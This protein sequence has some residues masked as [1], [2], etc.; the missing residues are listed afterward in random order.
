MATRK[1]KTQK[2]NAIPQEIKNEADRMVSNGL[3]EAFLGYNPQTSVQLSQVDTLFKN[4]RWY[5]ISNM[6]QVLSEIYVEHGLIQTIVDVPVDDGLRGG[7]K[8]KSDQLSE[9]QIQD[10]ETAI[11]RDDDLNTIGQAVKWTRLFGGGAILVITGQDPTL[12]LDVNSIAVGSP[13]EFRAVDMWELYW[14]KQ[15][16]EGFSAELQD[17]VFEYY[18]YYGKKVHKSRVMKMKGLTAPS[19]IRPRLRGWGF[20]IVEAIVRSINQYLKSNDLSFEVLDEFK[21]DVFKLK[22]LT[23][24]LLAPQ[25]E[26]KVRARVQLANRQKNYQNAIVLDGEDDYDHK[27]LSFAGLAEAMEGIRMQIASDLRMPL[28][29]LF[30]TGSKGFSSGEDDIENYNAMVENQV[31]RKVRYD[32]LRMLEIKCQ[33]LFGIVPDDL[34]IEFEPLRI[35]GAEE[36]ENVKT[37]KFSRALQAAQANLITTEEFRD[38]VNKDNLLPIQLDNSEEVIG[39][40]DEAK[41]EQAQSDQE[42]NGDGDKDP[43]ANKQDAKQPELIAKKDPGVKE[44]ANPKNPKNPKTGA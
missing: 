23:S 14:D 2:V 44:T 39:D 24:T 42:P 13:L 12:P 7:V 34:S 1:P 33:Q 29:K 36:E 19:F 17:E 28:T 30:G 37:Q 43:G 41:E 5:L 25:G 4:N 26:A 11:D 31:R 27:Q 40:L 20:S 3:N 8:I 18:S 22:N 38:A 16:T 35:L 9:D 21:L 6:R 15:N 32:I 10:L